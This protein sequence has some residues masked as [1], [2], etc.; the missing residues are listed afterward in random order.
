MTPQQIWIV[1]LA[2]IVLGASGAVI[3]GMRSGRIGKGKKTGALK[4]GKPGPA[5]KGALTKGAAAQ[6]ALPKQKATAAPKAKATEKETSALARKFDQAKRRF[7]KTIDK[8]ILREPIIGDKLRRN[9][10]MVLGWYDQK[11]K[12]DALRYHAGDSRTACKVCQGRNGKEYSLLE[13]DVVARI[14]PPSHADDGGRKE[15]LCRVTPVVAGEG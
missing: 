13:T 8:R 7:S 4:G 6:K 9:R 14:L 15:C 12:V 3:W 2:L 10:D 5:G 11:G 1:L